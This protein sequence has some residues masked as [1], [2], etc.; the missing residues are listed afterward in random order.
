MP[1]DG[2]KGFVKDDRLERPHMMLDMGD[3]TTVAIV[4]PAMMAIVLNAKVAGEVFPMILVGVSVRE[5]TF[6]CGCGKDD[7]NR[8]YKYRAEKQGRHSFTQQQAV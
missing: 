8:I 7:C 6:K 3:G 2:P 4:P 1:I 5:L